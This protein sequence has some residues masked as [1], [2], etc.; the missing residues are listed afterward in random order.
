VLR[1]RISA[2]AFFSDRWQC[3]SR[4]KLAEFESG[5]METRIADRFTVCSLMDVLSGNSVM[6][7]STFLPFIRISV[8]SRTL[9]PCLTL[10]SQNLPT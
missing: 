7:T 9:W 6:Q 3:V 8:Q 5:M 10:R 4:I 1:P 2:L